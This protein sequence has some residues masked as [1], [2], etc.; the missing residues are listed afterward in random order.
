MLCLRVPR[1][2]QARH[3]T[4]SSGFPSSVPPGDALVTRVPCRR[5]TAPTNTCEHTSVLSLLCPGDTVLEGPPS[6]QCQKLPGH[7][8]CS[9]RVVKV[10]LSLTPTHVLGK[11]TV[12]GVG[13][14]VGTRNLV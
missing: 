5:P 7:G 6:L 13:G 2:L 9:A 4:V 12:H 1:Y 11:G 3:N 8:D 10:M 14:A